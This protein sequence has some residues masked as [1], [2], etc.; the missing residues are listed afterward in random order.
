MAEVDDQAG[1]MLVLG[2]IVSRGL[3]STLLLKPV[4]YR[5]MQDTPSHIAS[6][7][8]RVSCWLIVMV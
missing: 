7:N 1:M 3:V 4:E 2:L 5:L 6:S 8:L